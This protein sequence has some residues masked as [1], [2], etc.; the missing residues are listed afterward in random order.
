MNLYDGF[1]GDKVPLCVDLPEQHFLRKGATY[2][3][4]GSSLTPEMHEY[5]SWWGEDRMP[6]N[7]FILTSSSNLKSALSSKQARITLN[8]DIACISDECNVDTM[9]LVQIQQNP[10]LYYEYVRPQC[11]EL[12]FYDNG[13]KISTDWSAPSLRKSMCANQNIDA[14]YD[15]CCANPSWAQPNGSLLCY[16]DLERT[17]YSTSRSRCKSE[18]PDGDT[19]DHYW[20]TNDNECTTADYWMVSLCRNHNL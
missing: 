20:T 1:I 12:S 17:T 15:A 9:R 5:P 4:L 6:D 7:V 2:R 14:A 13:K 18:Y 16:Y 3:L 8:A 19:C 10:P 11:V